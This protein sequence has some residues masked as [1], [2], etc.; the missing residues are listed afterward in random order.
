[1]VS[2]ARV[3]I[4]E[5]QMTNGISGRTCGGCTACC[6]THYNKKFDKPAGVWC[7]SCA[8]GVG[9]RIHGAHPDECAGFKCLWLL[10]EF[11]ESHRPDKLKIVADFQH[12]KVYG[13]VITVVRLWEASEGALD[14]SES[15]KLVK[16]SLESKYVVLQRRLVPNGGYRDQMNA[17][18]NFMSARELAELIRL[19]G[20]DEDEVVTET[21]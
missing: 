15:Q 17:P 13:R 1:M 20:S 3:H 19:L 4:V 18:A 9:C 7:S 2:K 5:S 11:P 8:I 16:A 10:G 21:P 12:E 6:K 14:K